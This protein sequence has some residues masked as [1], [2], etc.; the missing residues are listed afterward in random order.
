MW[1]RLKF[2]CCNDYVQ[3]AMAMAMAMD[4]AMQI[5]VCSAL[6]KIPLTHFGPVSG[7]AKSQACTDTHQHT[8]TER[9]LTL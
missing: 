1:Q 6:Y 9:G 8:D 3:L 7:Q 2:I 5:G 4:M